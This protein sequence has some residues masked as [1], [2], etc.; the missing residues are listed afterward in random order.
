M[1]GHLCFLAK[2][3]QNQQLCGVSPRESIPE[4]TFVNSIEDIFVTYVEGR[5]VSYSSAKYHV[6][7]STFPEFFLRQP[8]RWEG[9]GSGGEGA[10]S[11]PPT[12]CVTLI[13]TFSL[14]P[15]ETSL[16]ILNSCT[17]GIKKSFLPS[18]SWAQINTQD[19]NW[20]GTLT[21]KGTVLLQALSSYPDLVIK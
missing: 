19:F 6:V 5:G 4:A 15:L 11:L 12:K 9:G 8:W 1:R 20:W 14:L 3:T 2:S 7:I 16:G 18:W 17:F 10:S 13:D 21:G